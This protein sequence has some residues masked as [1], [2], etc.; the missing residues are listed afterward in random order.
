MKY[1]DIYI[2]GD[3]PTTCPLCGVR[4]EIIQELV[5]SSEIIQYHE[6]PSDNCRYTFT[7]MENWDKVLY[8]E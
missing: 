4:S 7:V 3:Q 8:N 1:T 5:D 6:C 2:M